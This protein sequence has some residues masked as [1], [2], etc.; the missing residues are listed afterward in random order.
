MK[1]VIKLWY[2]TT[3]VT[4]E[5]YLATC[6]CITHLRKCE[7]AHIGVLLH[8]RLSMAM[9]HAT[10]KKCHIERPTKMNNVQQW[11]DWENSSLNTSLE[12]STILQGN[13]FHP[14]IALSP[15]DYKHQHSSRAH[16]FAS[17]HSSTHFKHAN[18]IHTILCPRLTSAHSLA[19]QFLSVWSKF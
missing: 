16:W 6:Y 9:M 2:T 4:I 3:C 18:C 7:R 8:R 15:Y 19:L 13:E 11:I 5:L 17:P 1:G 14:T 10:E 12:S